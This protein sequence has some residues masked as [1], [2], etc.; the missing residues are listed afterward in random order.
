M[1]SVSF[2][3]Y[4]RLV[5]DN[6]NF[7]LLWIAQIISE[8]GDWFYALSIYNLLLELT[9]NAASVGLAVVL[10]V[11]PQTLT[12]PMA[13]VVNDRI[14]R[15]RVMITADVVRMIVVLG[16]LL[17]RTR[18]T[19]WLVYPLLLCETIM[20]SFFEPARNAV[21]PNITSSQT[22]IMANTLSSTT[23]SFNLA[24][25]ATLGGFFAAMFGREAAFLWNSLSFLISALLIRS[26]HFEEPHTEQS[27][28]FAA[29]DL[30]DF[31][32]IVEGVRYV[33]SHGRLFATV[34]VKG[35][36]GFMGANNVILPILG[37]RVFPVRIEGFS[38]QR[39]AI[40]AM[41]VLMGAR[42]AG[43]LIGPF[44]SGA[45]AGQKQQR[46]R[47][48]IL[49]GFVLAALG[50]VSVSF[51]QSVGPAVAAVVLAHAGGS[52]IWVF[53]TTLLHLYTEDR[54]RGRVFS[55]DL[56]FCTLTVSISS[57]LAGLAIDSGLPVRTFAYYMGLSML[58]PAAVWAVALRRTAAPATQSALRVSQEDD[59]APPL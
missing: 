27:R 57:F 46:L 14:S 48:G 26:M 50:Y 37:E 40:V 18:L 12:G 47:I 53:S 32:P 58:I 42:G 34:F 45:W 56:G 10:Q 30:V 24:V 54:F 9:G 13:G 3:G 23:W 29:A 44:V 7:W 36:L 38:G 25:G 2:A 11:L 43:A 16:M 5:R 17:V 51:A 49:I 59:F 15:K 21:I 22:L 39:G 4:W 6:R 19:S 1:Q 35:G 8:I 31:R 52:T 55:A 33:R 41:S 20:A 28:R